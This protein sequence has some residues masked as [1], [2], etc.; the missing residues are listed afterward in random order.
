MPEQVLCPEV[1]GLALGP[2]QPPFLGGGALCAP[3]PDVRQ[4]LP[5]GPGGP[6]VLCGASWLTP[7]LSPL[8]SA[9]APVLVGA[10]QPGPGGRDQGLSWG[11]GVR[12]V[13]SPWSDTQRGRV[14]SLSHVPPRAL[15]L[16]QGALGGVSCVHC[17]TRFRGGDAATT[18]GLSWPFSRHRQLPG[19]GLGRVWESD[20]HPHPHPH[21]GPGPGPTP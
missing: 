17:G 6:G 1:P 14:S 21:V 19:R 15:R 13:F 18:L 3:A 5:L 4:I 9:Q 11:P 7:S 16:G 12:Q 20:P 10:G 8:L 2:L